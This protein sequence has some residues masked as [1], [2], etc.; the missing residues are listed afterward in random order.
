LIRL[1]GGSYLKMKK[2][3]IIGCLLA[4]F[5]MMMLPSTS[6]ADSS[7]VNERAKTQEQYIEKILEEKE[8]N[9]NP[10][11]VARLW[12]WIRNIFAFGI[13]FVILKMI[14]GKNNT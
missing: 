13:V 7:T 5:I 6:V 3:I 1:L 4:V 14:L 11:C 12:L 9:A 2:R 8:N 10:L